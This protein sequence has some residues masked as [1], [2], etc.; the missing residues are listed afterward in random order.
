MNPPERNRR[1][2]QKAPR[3]LR[4]GGGLM[5]RQRPLRRVANDDR[6][7]YEDELRDTGHDGY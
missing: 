3:R 6:Y 2:K 1:Q 4:A 7:E 5:N